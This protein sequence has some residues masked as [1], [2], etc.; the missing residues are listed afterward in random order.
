MEQFPLM[1]HFEKHESQNHVFLNCERVLSVLYC[2]CYSDWLQTSC[3]TT[4]FYLLEGL[5]LAQV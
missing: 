4:F 1:K 3:P 2:G 5:D